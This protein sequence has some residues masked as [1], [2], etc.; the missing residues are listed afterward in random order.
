MLIAARGIQGIA[1]ATLIPSTMS[2]LFAMFPDKDDRMKAI[3]FI[4]AGFTSGAALGPILGGVLLDVSSWHAVFLIN[5]PAMLAVLFFVPR[6]VPEFANPA[7]PRVDLRSAGL[8]LLA[9]LP[10]TYGVKRF[11]QRHRRR[12]GR[13]ADRVRRRRRRAVPACASS[14]SPTRSSTSRCFASASSACRWRRWC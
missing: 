8:L 9:V 2:L 1:G 12:G 10:A 3:G 5:V 6:F 4:S 11:A 7:A 14:G 13:V